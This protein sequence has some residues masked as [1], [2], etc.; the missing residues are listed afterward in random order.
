MSNRIDKIKLNHWLNIRKTTIEVLNELLSKDLNYESNFENLDE[1]DERVI[2][3][4]GSALSIPVE[5]IL[6]EDDVPS[7][8]YNSKEAIRN[9]LRCLALNHIMDFRKKK[10]NFGNVV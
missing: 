3:K 1:I 9:Q 6:I 10:M 2:K 4:I 5:N 7:F 8:I